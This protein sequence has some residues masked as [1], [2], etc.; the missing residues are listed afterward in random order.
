M[1]TLK[2]KSVKKDQLFY[3]KWQYVTHYQQ[4]ESHVLRELDHKSVD[5]RLDWIAERSSMRKFRWNG[6]MLSQL[7][8]EPPRV[9]AEIRQC[10]HD[11]VDVL[12]GLDE[13]HKLVVSTHSFS[14]Y[15][16]NTSLF[17]RLETML[18]ITVIKR[19]E[20][21][22][23]RTQ[24]TILLTDPK[25][26]YRSYFAL[27]QLTQEHKQAL[28]RFFHNQTQIRLSPSL[29][30]WC[31]SRYSRLQDYYFIDHNGAADLTMLNLVHPGL[32]RKTLQ[33]LPR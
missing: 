23:D 28:V 31:T 3:D 1:P 10:L 4:P 2:F 17:D 32:I 29:L 8:H 6:N 21:S 18:G 25:H 7:T 20:A 15:T 9:T 19:C 12:S 24:G 16:N 30:A 13:P 26:S 22:I 5:V 33:I 27:V 11:L 14:I